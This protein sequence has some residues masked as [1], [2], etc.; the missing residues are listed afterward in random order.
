MPSVRQYGKQTKLEV[1]RCE[2]ILCPSWPPLIL[3][4]A[5]LATFKD[6]GTLETLYKPLVSKEASGSCDSEEVHLI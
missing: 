4:K 5:D 6:L 1:R 3:T 2:V